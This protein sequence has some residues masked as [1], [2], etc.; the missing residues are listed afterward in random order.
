MGSI[1]FVSLSSFS[2]HCAETDQFY[3]TNA[4]IR[5]S[6]QE[7]N[8]FFHQRIQM[9]L[10][11]SNHAKSLLGCR[12]VAA[13]VLTEVLGEFSIK[14]YAKDKYF[15]KVSLFAQHSPL[16][17][18]YPEDSIDDESYRSHSIYR[19]RPFPFNTV[20]I[21]RTINING[22][23]V[24]TD[25]VGHFSII[26]RAYYKNFLKGLAQGLTEEQAEMMAINKGIKQE[27]NFLGYTIGGTLAFGDLEA[28]YQGLKFA[29]HMCEG[30]NPHLKLAN[31]Q[32]VENPQNAFD[33]RKYVNPKMDE[34]FNVSL[35]SPR[36]WRLMGKDILKA[37][38]KN[39]RDPD[40]LKRE[41][42]YKGRT[43]ETLNDKLIEKFVKDNPQ[44]NRSN[45]LLS[46]NVNCNAL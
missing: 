32:W 40:Y 21:A 7:L 4:V 8:D 35:W 20:A 16:V 6:G 22:I 38:C 44:Y 27:V 18:R 11:I 25:K 39:K 12:E 17:E 41:E 36:I 19:H 45:Q 31:G 14:E 26:G 37:Y 34:A 13:Q 29:R 42:N 28:N 43:K 46:K 3:A 24:G 1:V 15:S 33:I 30:E 2:L 9:G 23:Y 10:D 5:E